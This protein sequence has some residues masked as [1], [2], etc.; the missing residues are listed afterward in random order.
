MRE[1]IGGTGPQL[2]V[3]ADSEAMQAVVAQAG[4]VAALDSTILLTGESGVG[5]GMLAR[6][7]HA[8]SDRREQ[9]FVTVSCPALPRELLES[10]LFGHEKG[11]FT[12]AVRRRRGKI[13][14]AKGGTLFLDEIGDLPIDLQPKLLNVLQDRQ[15]QRLGG[16]ET[17]QADV[18]II[19]A[20]NLDLDQRMREGQFREDLFYRLSVI[21]IEVPPL[22]ERLEELR[23]LSASMLGRMAQQGGRRKIKLSKEAIAAMQAYDWPGNVRQ[24]ENVLERSAAFCDGGVIEARDL[25]GAVRGSKPSGRVP[26]GIGG[27]ALS[28]LERE[29]LIQ[30]L[31]ICNGNKAETARRLEITEKSV[32]NKLKRHGLM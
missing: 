5:K 2:E 24:L 16:E 22:R 11:A 10:E 26:A 31:K 27:I 19:A 23:G 28:D 20:T 29:S 17:L 15:F 12:G 32:Y 18:R 30:T 14:A 21:P 1:A 25:P 13:E 9:P 8:S 3:V 4:K 7:I 6:Y